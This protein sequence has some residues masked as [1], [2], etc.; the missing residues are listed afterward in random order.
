LTPVKTAAGSTK[1]DQAAF[2]APMVMPGDYTLKLKVGDKEFTD[3]ITLVHD[4]SNTDFT[5][6]D[7]EAQHKAAMEMYGMQSSLNGLIEEVNAEQ[8]LLKANTEKVKNAK[9]KKVL[10]DYATQLETLRATLLATKQKSIFADEEQLRERL[11]EVYGT[12]LNQESKPSNLQLERVAVLQKQLSDAKE[13]HGAISKQ[14]AEKVKALMG[15]EG[16][17]TPPEVL[18]DK[19]GK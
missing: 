11:S 2:T 6:A 18:M 14:Y 5:L 8:Q 12:V 16:I 4:M 1:M 10:G 13:K 7:R 17:T 15:K 19:N 3:K 9:A